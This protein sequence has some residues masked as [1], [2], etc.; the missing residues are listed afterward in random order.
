MLCKDR[1]S[2]SYSEAFK[3]QV[4][5]EL[6]SGRLDSIES[7]RCVGSSNFDIFKIS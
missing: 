6:E 3:L 1:I 2:V 5:S 7:A 4:I